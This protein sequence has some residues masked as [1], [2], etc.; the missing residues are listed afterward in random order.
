MK[1]KLITFALI[2]ITSS[3]FA[4][5]RTTFWKNSSKNNIVTFDN[6]MQ[7]SLNQVFDINIKGIDFCITKILILKR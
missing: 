1:K 7:V 6:R 5:Q 2:A 4:Q 3:S